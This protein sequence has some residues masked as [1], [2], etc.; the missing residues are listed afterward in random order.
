MKKLDWYILKKFLSTFFFSIFLFTVVSIVV[1]ISEK[2]DNFVKSGLSLYQIFMQYYIGFIPY[3]IALLFP[4]FVLIAV[5][6]FTSKMATRS[7]IVAILSS[8]TSFK[9]FLR[10]YVIGGLLLAILLGWANQTLIP[11]AN[12]I[13]V[14]F[15]AKYVDISSTYNPLLTH[16]SDFYFKLDP[17]TYAS[18]QNYDTFLKRGS[19]F[20][21]YTIKNYEAVKNIRASSIRWDT[22]THKWN[23]YWAMYRYIYSN[24]EKDTLK[25]QAY[26]L[27]YHFSPDDIGE[28]DYKKDRL[29]TAALKKYI[30]EGEA[31][32]IEGLK[33]YKV[34]LYRRY[35]SAATVFI[36][37]LIGGIIASKKVRGGSGL[38]LAIGFLT[39]AAYIIFDKFSTVFA[40]KGNLPPLLAAWIPNIIFLIVTIYFYIRAPK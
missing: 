38:H 7:E 26:L 15:Q 14:S 3:I 12:K 1:D 24:H 10:P 36:L 22:S 25:P 32:N 33:T 29:T 13:R 37:A 5:I 34:E 17:Y 23:M 9:R 2:A 16:E 40:T 11:N 18:V 20:F 31:K 6:F 8:G 27:N 19:P 28:D 21:L 4:L 30:K 39:G 35:A